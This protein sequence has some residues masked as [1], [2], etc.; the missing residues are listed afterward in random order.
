MN[1]S[2]A[3]QRQEI[4]AEWEMPGDLEDVAFCHNPDGKFI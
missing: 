4:E 1:P 3:A 2:A